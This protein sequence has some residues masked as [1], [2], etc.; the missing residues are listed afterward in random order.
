M[1][2][3]AKLEAL[4]EIGLTDGESKAYLTL[5]ELGTSTVGPLARKS[6]I[7]YSNIYQVL[8]RLIN[9]GLASFVMK[10]KTKHFQA[11]NPDNLFDYVERREKEIAKQ[12]EIL[13]DLI[14]K[15]KAVQKRPEQEAEIYVGLKGLKAAY[16]K[17]LQDGGT[18]WLFFYIHSEEYAKE[19]DTFFRSISNLFRKAKISVRGVCNAE[20]K[21]SKFPKTAT[22]MRI[23]Y[24]DFPIPGIIDIYGDKILLVS[25]S[26]RPVAFLIKSNQ[27]SS[28]LRA[29][30]NMAWE[31]AK[32]P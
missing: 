2:M 3:S 8:E 13:K 28:S 15:I 1:D 11:V 20:Y 27:I 14:P 30:F 4:K 24:A 16:L 5:L 12:K 23:K 22:F 9:K 21:K 10:N 18:E 32:L 6:G 7:A 29:Y 26:S 19:S 25:W 31:S 17:M